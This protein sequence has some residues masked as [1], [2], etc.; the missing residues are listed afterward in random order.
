MKCLPPK[1]REENLRETRVKVP[2]VETFQPVLRETPL[3]APSDSADG[4]VEFIDITDHSELL[5]E[6]SSTECTTCTPS[7]SLSHLLELR[8]CESCCLA[9]V[10]LLELEQCHK[11]F[12]KR[13]RLQHQQFIVDLLTIS[14]KRQTHTS[15]TLRTYTLLG[16]DICKTAL[17]TVLGISAKRLRKVQRLHKAGVTTAVTRA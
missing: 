6:F 4:S 5:H 14:A 9:T 2:S 11:S 15:H 13:P 16:K 10:S 17:T 1:L 3:P 7:A 8:C 12:K